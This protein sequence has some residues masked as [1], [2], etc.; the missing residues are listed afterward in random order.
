MN[1]K[2]YDSTEHKDAAEILLASRDMSKELADDL[3]QAGFIVFDA[4]MPVAMGFYRHM[5]GN[6]AVF[7]SYITNSK[8]SSKDRNNALDLITEKLLERCKSEGFR[9]A[10]AF[11]KNANVV[12]RAC[13]HGFHRM[14]MD[15]AMLSLKN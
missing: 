15:F 12:N 7:D 1:I 2:R 14:P 11:S 8:A 3:P 13:K 10:I 5:E 6:Y 4:D 9:G